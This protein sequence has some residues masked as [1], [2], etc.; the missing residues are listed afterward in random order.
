MSS[1]GG[2]VDCGVGESWPFE[3]WGPVEFQ[4]II[5]RPEIYNPKYM[6]GDPN[7][8]LTL[9]IR[10]GWYEERMRAR[11]IPYEEVLPKVW[12]GQLPKAVHHRRGRKRL[13]TSEATIVDQALSQWDSSWNGTDYVH[14]AKEGPWL[15]LLDAV[16][17]ALWKDGRLPKSGP[18]A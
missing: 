2:I 15:D 18:S 13:N 12:K 3:A 9:A 16:N 7:K 8:I 11:G 14:R 17:L 10:V 4:G 5:E 6:K 1:L